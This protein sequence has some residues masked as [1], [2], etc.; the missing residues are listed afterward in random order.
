MSYRMHTAPT[1]PP[2]RVIAFTGLLVALLIA[3]LFPVL[4]GRLT[5]SEGRIA[6]Q[7]VRAPRE[8]RYN[9]EFLRGQL[10]DQRAK[11]VQTVVTYDVAVR[12]QQLGKLTEIVARITGQRDSPGFSRA[13]R[14]EG[15]QRIQGV[16]LTQEQRGYIL[17]F[18]PE[19]WNKTV[20]EAIRLLSQVLEEPFS[21]TELDS[22]RAS[23]R[24]RVREGLLSIQGDVAVA[25]VQPLVLPT[26]REDDGE[27]LKARERARASVEPQVQ[28]YAKGQVIVREGDIID[29]PKYEA[30]KEAGLLDFHLDKLDLAAVAMIALLSAGALGLYIQVFQPPSLN[31]T[32]RLVAIAFLIG[33]LVL[34]AKLYLPLVLP[35]SQRRFLAY[36][37]PVAAVPMLV[38]ALFEAPFALVVAAVSMMLTTFTALYIPDVSG[39]VGLSPIQPLQLSAAYL[40]GGLAGVLV[41]QRAERLNHFFLAGVAVTL[42]SFLG[43]CAFWF[44]D[45]SRRPMDLAWMAGSSVIAGGLS[46]V[47]TV[48]L[49]A[50]LGSVFGVTTRLQLMELGQL[51][52]PLLRRL[53]DEAPGTFHH[54]IIVGNLAERAADLIGADSLLVRVGSYYHDIGKM[55]RPGFFIENQLSGTNPHDGLDPVTSTEILQEHVRHGL[56]LAR[57]HRLPE[58]VRNFIPEH[59]GTRLVAYFYRLA[60]QADPQVDP[61]RFTYAGPRPGSRET[62]IVMLADSTE[63]MVRAAKDRSHERIEAMVESVIAE[64]LAEGQFDDCD[65]TL[66]DLRVIAASFKQNLRAIYH[67]RIEYPAPTPAE[68]QRRRAAALPPAS[69]NRLTVINGTAP[70]APLPASD[71]HAPPAAVDAEPPTEQPVEARPATGSSG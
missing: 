47:L 33:G 16:T 40:F 71:G 32:R 29:R 22:R 42:A 17:D 59:H 9:S 64:R 34:A 51:N 27:T 46:A 56:E 28:V 4:P 35:D 39:I 7:T 66:R 41:M 1:I 70:P 15:I 38:A 50:L 14:D 69:Q 2:A 24:N 45:G 19:Q 68:Q 61:A 3:A 26:Q 6:S 62:A 20:D 12:N 30:L 63:A 36:V 18:T 53:Q 43:L 49:F 11:S 5:V 58:K 31:S 13:T 25:L 44:L 57:R 10:Q 54:S 8:I 52:A 37:L 48:G 65:L 55:A 67:P 21:A 23:V 60:A